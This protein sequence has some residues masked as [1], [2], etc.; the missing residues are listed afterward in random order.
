[1]GKFDDEMYLYLTN[2]KYFADLINA[3]CFE[4]EQVRK[5]RRWQIGAG[6]N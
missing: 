2:K 3:G 5:T 4:G 1:M 6:L